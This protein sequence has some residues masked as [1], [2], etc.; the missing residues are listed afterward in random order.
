MLLQSDEE[1]RRFAPWAVD[2]R[3]AAAGGIIVEKVLP[4]QDGRCIFLGDDDTCSIYE[5]RPLSCEQFEC[6]RH[7]NQGGG[8]NG[9]HGEFLNRNPRVLA[10]LQGL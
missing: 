6:V 2:A 9:A 3:I 10:V 1:R 4:Y 5:V 7:F 8:G